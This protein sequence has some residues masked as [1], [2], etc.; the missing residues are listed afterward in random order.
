MRKM[1]VLYLI[2]PLLLDFPSLNGISEVCSFCPSVLGTLK[3]DKKKL[4]CYTVV[5]LA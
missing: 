1:N 3:T 4:H 2:N 5:V